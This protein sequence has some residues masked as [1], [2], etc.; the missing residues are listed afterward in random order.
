MHVDGTAGSR[1]EPDRPRRTESTRTMSESTTTNEGPGSAA[2]PA[3]S[4]APDDTRALKR[5]LKIIVVF[6]VILVVVF[7][8][9]Y[10]LGQHQAS[11]PSIADQGVAAAEAAVKEKPN[12]VAGRLGLATTYARAGRNEEAVAQYDEVLRVDPKN[13]GALLGR[14]TL[15]FRTGEYAKAKDD[16]TAFVGGSGTGEF[17]SGD[18]QL[19][20]G[21]YF[22]GAAE[23]QLQDPTSAATHL[24]SALQIDKSDADAWDALG[25]AQV[26]LQ[27]YSEAANS[28]QRALVFIP[29]GWCD[30]YAGLKTAYT[31][32]SDA[33]GVEFAD[34]MRQ[35]CE[36][37]TDA[38]VARLSTMTKG[39]FRIP[40][41]LALGLAAEKSGDM[42]AAKDWYEQ[43][44]KIEPENVAALTALARIDVK[45]SPSSTPTEPQ[46]SASA[47]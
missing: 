15:W 35:M 30:P 40:S 19:E 8:V 14:G 12:D 7:G 18:P 38:A 4:P 33:Q 22:L 17:A 24:Q 9:I 31:G 1:N 34:S 5:L 11:A 25:T 6:T 13:R 23:L 44:V 45:G 39:G 26:A 3:G 32:L 46:P 36:G 2:P 16:L 20:E 43:V 21:Y 29:S 37:D 41:M 27:Q 10:Y 47:S 42:A 28:F